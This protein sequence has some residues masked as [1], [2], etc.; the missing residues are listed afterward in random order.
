MLCSTYSIHHVTSLVD[1]KVNGTMEKA[2]S[3]K[4]HGLWTIQIYIFLDISLLTQRRYLDVVSTF[5][6]RYGRQMDVETTL[7]V[8]WVS[9]YHII[10]IIHIL[11]L[12]KEVSWN[13][14]YPTPMRHVVRY[15][16]VRLALVVVFESSLLIG[17]LMMPKK[18]LKEH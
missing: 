10:S 4:K 6:E 12:L 16:Q 3:L 1:W 18:G 2:L 15:Q 8:Y 11:T 14:D 9:V 17:R 13:L 7:R 5:F